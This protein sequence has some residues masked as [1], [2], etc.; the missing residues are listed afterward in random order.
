MGRRARRGRERLNSIVGLL[1]RF[2]YGLRAAGRRQ[3][4]YPKQ[5]GGGDTCGSRTQSGWLHSNWSPV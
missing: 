2:E 1:R 4:Q 5:G 3:N